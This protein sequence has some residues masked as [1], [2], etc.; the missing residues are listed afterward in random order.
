MSQG[1]SFIQWLCETSGLTQKELAARLEVSA[2]LI[3][4]IIKGERHLTLELLRAIS[5]EFRL[6]LHLVYERAGI[7]DSAASFQETVI[8]QAL[9]D[10]HPPPGSLLVQ[11]KNPRFALQ[12][13]LSGRLDNETIDK[14]ADIVELELRYSEKKQKPTD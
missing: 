7:L 2:S 12:Y 11:L 9:V 1:G 14:L 5:R 13:C 3:T 6:P 8:S 4:R 10:T